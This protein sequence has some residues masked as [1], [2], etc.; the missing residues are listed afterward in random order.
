MRNLQLAFA[1]QYRRF[2]QTGLAAKVPGLS[3]SNLS[4]YE[5]GLGT[6]SDDLLARIM[7]VLEFPF[8]FLDLDIVNNVDCKHY[9]K[10]ASVKAQDRD[11]IDRFISLSAYCFDWMT[12][13]VD[14]PDFKFKYIDVDSGTTP[15]EIAIYI[16]RQFSLG[17]APMENMCNF[18]ER[19]GIPVFFW[20]CECEEFDGVSLI[21][22][23]GNHIIIVNKNMSNDRKRFSLAH[24]LGHI[25]MHQCYDF[26]IPEV[27]NKEKE[28]NRFAA[29]LLMPSQGIKG[30]LLNIKF[31]NLPTLKSYWLTSMASIILRAKI[32]EQIDDNKYI[33]LRNELSRRAWLKAEPYDVF[34]DEPT[35]IRKAYGLITERVGYGNEQISRLCKIPLD[36]IEEVFNFQSK[37]IPLKLKVS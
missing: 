7:S 13:F 27:R 22:D 32:L 15:E 30:S 10:K 8:G 24:E 5:K 3:Q 31:S 2:T 9:R 33:M 6:L 28:A 35:V 1:R 25:I 17:I 34:L 18:L 21:T 4:N 11:K 12:E 26:F 23:K 29:E 37:I 19:N 16:R 14:F 36:V 20:D